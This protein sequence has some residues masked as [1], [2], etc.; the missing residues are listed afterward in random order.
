MSKKCGNS[1]SLS[2]IMKTALAIVV[3]F[4]QFK[5]VILA[6]GKQTRWSCSFLRFLYIL[7]ILF[8]RV[9]SISCTLVQMKADI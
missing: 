5:P 7:L 3:F 1:A 6:E 8:Q 2:E 4:L 9:V